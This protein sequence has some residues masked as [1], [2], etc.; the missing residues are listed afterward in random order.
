M[1]NFDIGDWFSDSTPFIPTSIPANRISI[2]QTMMAYLGKISNGNI[3][4]QSFNSSMGLASGLR[5]LCTACKQDKKLDFNDVGSKTI[6]DIVS[7]PLIIEWIKTHRHEA[8]ENA[9]LACANPTSKMQLIHTCKN[10]APP[11]PKVKEVQPTERK[12]KVVE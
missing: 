9:C 3:L 6:M 4:I 10:C 7:A 12:M 5:L 11:T 1:G 2:D 8:E